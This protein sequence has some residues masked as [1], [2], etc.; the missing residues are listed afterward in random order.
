MSKPI[1]HESCIEEQFLN[2]KIATFAENDNQTS[3]TGNEM[4]SGSGPVSPL[5]S[6]RSLQS[7]IDS[8]N[9]A[10]WQKEEEASGD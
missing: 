5:L 3:Q 6:K 2:E 10:T 4:L 8:L 9:L 1:I 7:K